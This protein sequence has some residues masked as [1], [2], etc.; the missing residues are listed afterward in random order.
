MIR[1][2]PRSTLFPYTTLFRSLSHELRT[3]LMPLIALL[4]D[5]AA[6][7]RR[8][9][10]DLDA[11]AIMRRNLDLETHLIDDLLDL[12]RMTGGKLQLRR[13]MTDV[14]LCLQQ[15]IGICQA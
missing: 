11:F 12:T 13:E 8:S 15:A 2:P 14:H 4:Q 6:D 7:Q 1:R 10:E 9:V 5:L 3:P